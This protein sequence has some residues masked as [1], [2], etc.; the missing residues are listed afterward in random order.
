MPD[1]IQQPQFEVKATESKEGVVHLYANVSHL[2]WTGMDIT[3]QLYQIVQ[4]NRDI[5][6]QI[7]APNEIR[8]SASITFSWTSAK[9]FHK[10]LTEVIERY[11][12]VYGPINTDFRLI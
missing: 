8:Q 10:Q 2:V 3:A 5:P 9:L 11:E 12:K 4:P 1:E 7:N 6:E